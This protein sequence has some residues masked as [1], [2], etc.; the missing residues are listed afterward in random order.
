MDTDG[1][2]IFIVP[3]DTFKMTSNKSLVKFMFENGWITHLTEFEN[4]KLFDGASVGI[5]IFRY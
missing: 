4:E 2:L 5:I 1:E 3:S